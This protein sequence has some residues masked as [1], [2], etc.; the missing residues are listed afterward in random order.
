[1]I[2]GPCLPPDLPPVKDRVEKCVKGSSYLC[3]GNVRYWDG[4][5]IR[6]TV[7]ERAYYN[8]RKKEKKAYYKIYN[9]VN[10]DKLKILHKRYYKENKKKIKVYGETY[11]SQR[12]KRLIERRKTDPVYKLKCS[13]STNL[14]MSLKAQRA[15]KNK[16]TLEYSCCSVE[17]MLAHLENQFTDGMTWENW[18]PDG[19]HVDHRRPKASFNLQNEEEIYMMQHWTNLQP[20]WAKENMVKHNK[21]NPETFTHEWMGI[22][23]GWQLK[24][25]SFQQ[26]IL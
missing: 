8:A 18:R 22:D 20:M 1:M 7:R 5:Q 19:W 10:K 16:R 24:N 9:K 25:Y 14:Y 3:R 26:L 21:F 4:K 23:I 11:R 6:D 12:N 17:F 15:S 13:L 2:W